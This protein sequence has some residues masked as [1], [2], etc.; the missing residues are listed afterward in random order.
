[1]VVD[2][3]AQRMWRRPV[4]SPAATLG[5]R[6][7]RAP[8]QGCL[9]AWDAAR[10]SCLRR[11]GGTNTGRHKH[12]HKHGQTQ[13][14]GQTQRWQDLLVGNQGSDLWLHM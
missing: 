6:L 11:M 9:G 14:E 12:K 5:L 3:G 1:M 7:S 8:G 13:R 4:A 10:A 2:C